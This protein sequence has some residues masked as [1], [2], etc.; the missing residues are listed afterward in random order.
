MARRFTLTPSAPFQLS[1]SAEFFRGFT[2]ASGT[3]TDAKDALLLALRADKTFAPVAVAL[4]QRGELLEGE[5]FG[6]A[7][8]ATVKAQVARVL[9]LDV[10]GSGWMALGKREPVVGALQR[11]HPGFLPVCF[12]SPYEAAIWGVL[13]QRIN[14]KQAAALKK[15]L[16]AEHGDSVTT[17]FGDV[18]VTPSPT[19]LLAVKSV[20]GIP[21]EKLTRLH[22]VAHAAAKGLLDAERLRGMDQEAALKE[23]EEIRGV[24]AWTAEHVLMRGA[25]LADALPSAEPR[26]LRGVQQAYGLK[27]EP[28]QKEYEALAENWRPY[29]MWVCILAVRELA[30]TPGWH[31]RAN[32]GKRVVAAR[33]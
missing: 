2:P 29:R 25:G 24:G 6:E 13:A 31:G 9:S 21:E 1:A 19:Q 11:A 10:D 7:D 30:K 16:A 32:R 28:T 33:T 20:K 4:R 22:A 3:A 23:L 26:V 17:P 14:M 15:K 27:K 12:P 8:T 5:L 18:A